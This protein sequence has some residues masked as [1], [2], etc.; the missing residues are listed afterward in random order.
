MV[1]LVKIQD[2][3]YDKNLV[4]QQICEFIVD[5]PDDFIDL[6]KAATGSIAVAPNGDVMVVNASGEWVKFGG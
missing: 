3:V 1:K 2:G 4:Q 5:S 6:P